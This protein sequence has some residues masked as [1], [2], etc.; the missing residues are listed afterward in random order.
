MA[1]N[2]SAQLHTALRTVHARMAAVLATIRLW[3]SH[4]PTYE[5][6]RRCELAQ[7]YLETRLAEMK[8]ARP[9]QEL[10]H[11]IDLTEAA[12]RTVRT[13][14]QDMTTAGVLTESF[15]YRGRLLLTGLTKSLRD[16]EY[17][18]DRG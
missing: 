16:L 10:R 13:L 7:V 2:T 15:S 8:S 4:A 12:V 6:A 1:E 9:G 14:A 5:M 18:H 17:W 11:A 3:E